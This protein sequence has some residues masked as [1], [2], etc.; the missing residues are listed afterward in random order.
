MHSLE[1]ILTLAFFGR[2]KKVL[3]T[4]LTLPSIPDLRNGVMIISTLRYEFYYFYVNI[5]FI[6]CND[7]FKFCCVCVILTTSFH[8]RNDGGSGRILLEWDVKV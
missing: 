8:R 7:L 6:W 4:S 3:V 1:K 5:I 2:F